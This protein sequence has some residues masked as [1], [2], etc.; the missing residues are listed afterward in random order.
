MAPAVEESQKSS[1][2]DNVQERRAL[3]ITAKA[4]EIEKVSTPH[5]A[6]CHSDRKRV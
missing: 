4:K 2:D 3:A 1:P 5:V 6:D